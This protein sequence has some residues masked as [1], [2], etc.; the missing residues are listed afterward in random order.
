VVLICLFLMIN[1]VNIFSNVIGHLYILFWKVFI[2]YML[3]LLVVFFLVHKNLYIIGLQ[4]LDY[5]HVVW[6]MLSRTFFFTSFSTHKDAFILGWI[7]RS[8]FFWSCVSLNL[9][10]LKKLF[11]KVV[12]TIYTITNSIGEFVLLN[13]FANKCVIVRLLNVSHAGRYAVV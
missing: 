11:S 8:E 9:I 2:C 10:Y 6:V 3:F 7:F 4:V 1:K 12:L 5:W 13:I